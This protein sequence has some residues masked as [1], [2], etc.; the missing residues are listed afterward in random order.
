VGRNWVQFQTDLVFYDS[1]NS[2][3]KMT[4]VAYINQILE[5]RVK[6]W[7]EDYRDF[8]LE[9]DQDSG[10]GPTV[11]KKGKNIVQKWKEQ[12]GLEYYFNISHSPDIPPIEKAWQA[13]KEY[14]SKFEY[15]DKMELEELAAEGWHHGDAKSNQ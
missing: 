1:S 4:Q 14:I 5:P 3:G 8:V 7:I 2:N 13:W 10:H 15:Y 12:H 6:P 9:E 11:P